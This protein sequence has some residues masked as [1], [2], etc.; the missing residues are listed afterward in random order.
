LIRECSP[1]HFD[2]RGLLAR[3]GDGESSERLVFVCADVDEEPLGVLVEVNEGLGL[4]V[5]NARS[6]FD[7][8]V[9]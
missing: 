3:C 5:E 6:L 8:S 7:E 1:D 4:S 9:H 2:E